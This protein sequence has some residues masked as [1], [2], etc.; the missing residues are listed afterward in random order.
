M[1]KKRVSGANEALYN[2]PFNLIRVVLDGVGWALRANRWLSEQGETYDVVHVHLQMAS[3]VLTFINRKLRCRM[4]YTFHGDNYRV[5]LKSRVKVPWYLRLISPDLVLMRHV[6]KVVVLNKSIYAGLVESGKI[7]AEKLVAI[8]NGIDVEKYRPDIDTSGVRSEYAMEGRPTVL[9]AG[10]ISPRKG[11]EYLIRAAAILVNDS[12]YSGLLFI[13]A[14]NLTGDREYAGRME[15]LIRELGL[16]NNVRM[17]GNV[18]HDKL[19]GLYVAS[20]LLVCPSPEEPYPTV[21]LEAMACG[22]P[23]V[24]TRVGGMLEQIVDGWNGFLVEPENAETLAEKIKYLVDHPE[25]RQQMGLNSRKRAVEEFDWERV[26][27]RY[28]EVYRGILE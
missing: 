10:N 4:V 23:V 21:V 15:A 13:L 18:P 7:P 14:G 12:G 1:V 22:R 20:D 11:V 2:F 8:G 6:R 9:F 28:L 26:A 27:V 25:E 16:E 24:G 19:I 17:I 3:T 5:K